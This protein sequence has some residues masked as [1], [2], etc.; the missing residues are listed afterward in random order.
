MSDPHFSS[1]H[2]TAS[3]IDADS[4]YQPVTLTFINAG[5]SSVDLNQAVLSFSACGAADSFGVISGSLAETKVPVITVEDGWPLKTT[6]IEFAYGGPMLLAAGQSDTLTFHMSA[7]QV[8]FEVTQWL[9]LLAS[10]EQPNADDDDGEAVI[11]VPKPE[12]EPEPEPTSEPQAETASVSVQVSPISSGSWYQ[13]I[14]L[15]LTNITSQSIDFTLAEIEFFATGHP[16]EYSPFGGSLVGSNSPVAKRDGGWPL[17]K[18]TLTLQ[19]GGNLQLDAGK[20]GTLTFSL[21]ATQTPVT[22]GEVRVTLRSDPA[23]QGELIVVMPSSGVAGIGDPTLTLITE[24]GAQTAHSLSWN[25]RN[26]LKNLAYGRYCIQT[27]SLENATARLTPAQSQQQ[28]TLS[29]VN[30]PC[31]ININY[32]SPVFFASALLSLTPNASVKEGEIDIELTQAATT[33]TVAQRFEPGKTTQVSQLTHQVVCDARIKTTRINNIEFSAAAEPKTFKPN[34]DAVMSVILDYQFKPVS[35][36]GMIFAT[37]Q[38]TGLP[39]GSQKISVS[40]VSKDRATQYY[41][42]L[43]GAGEMAIPYALAAGDYWLN[44]KKLTV[45]GRRYIPLTDTPVTVSAVSKRLVLV[46]DKG[47]DLQV[48][49]WPDY[50]AHGGVTVNSSSSV[51]AY[52]NVPVSALFKYDGFDGGGDPIPA[53]EVDSNGDGYLDLVSLPVHQ[54]C[55]VARQIELASGLA[56]MPVMVVYTAN[57]SGGSAVPDLA[58]SQRLRNHFGSFI[59]QCVAA[60]SYKD[61]DHPVPVTFVL[62]PDFL[63]AMQQEPSGYQALRKANSVQ[64]NSLLQKAVS[65]LKP[66]LNYTTPV[67]PHFDDSLYGYLQAINY[68]VH[69]FAPDVAFGWQTNVWATGGADWVLRDN[70]DSRDYADQ[71][72]TYLDELGV[73]QGAYVPDFIVFD[74]FERDCFSPDALAH[75]GWNATS[76]LNYLKLVKYT[77]SGLNK[78]AMIWQIPGGHMPTESEGTSMLSSA[79]FASGGSFFMGDTRI[80]SDVNK[81]SKALRNTAVNPV[82]YGVKTVGEFLLKDQ[83]YDW[84]QA[85]VDNLT[86]YNIFSILWGGGSTVSITSIQSNGTDGGWLAQKMREYYAAPNYFAD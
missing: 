25:S 10:G 65:D 40:L 47:V 74:K 28:I 78:P 80:G 63:G 46:F 19:A 30:S 53:A 86:D 76:W 34:K 33:Q 14:T 22:L 51:T 56:V 49:G 4:W 9:L 27:D 3:A 68:I 60:Q 71:V 72:V 37:L 66:I 81:V 57:A 58:D 45:D 23:R 70:V 39:A 18:N 75:Y 11:P 1:L 55:S 16:D 42:T 8:P 50:L 59:T 24:S 43:N 69:T 20:T 6:R 73:Y 52:N 29:A 44:A 21:S 64:V 82:N 62:N 35:S 36:A 48:R 12:P 79:H 7:S 61:E 38:A 41:F 54:T 15:S 13:K 77:A 17:E 5:S 85:Q 31:I 32:E 2:V 67:L 83:G 84:G 26:S